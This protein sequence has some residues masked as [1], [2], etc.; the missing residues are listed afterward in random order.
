MKYTVTL[1]KPALV[2]AGV[3]LVVVRPGRQGEKQV[4]RLSDTPVPHA[5][6]AALEDHR[7]VTSSWGG[8]ENSAR[9]KDFREGSGPTSCLLAIKRHG[10]FSSPGHVRDHEPFFIHWDRAIPQLGYPQPWHRAALDGSGAQALPCG[11]NQAPGV[12]LPLPGYPQP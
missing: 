1:P 10:H 5:G 3:S 8:R 4:A 12:H 2:S 11:S 7:A 6:Q 9:H